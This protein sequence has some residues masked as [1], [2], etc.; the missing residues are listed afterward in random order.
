[1]LKYTV[2]STKWGYFGLAGTQ[3]GIVRTSLPAKSFREVESRLLNGLTAAQPDQDLYRSLQRQIIAYF[4]GS[5]V[6]FSKAVPVIL[7]ELSE[8]QRCILMACRKIKCGR[9]ISYAKLTETADRPGAARAA[10]NALAANP[11]PLIIPCHRVLRGDGKIGGFSAPG[12]RNMKQMLLRHEESMSRHRL[13]YALKGN[14][15]R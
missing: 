15:S 14:K 8:F 2:F 3:A 12:G 6:D 9:T 5:Y 1:M 13:R 11:L 7:D 4:E 10:G